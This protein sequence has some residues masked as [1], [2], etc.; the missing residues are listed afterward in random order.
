MKKCQKKPPKSTKKCKKKCKKD[1]KKEKTGQHFRQLQVSV[2]PLCQKT[3]CK[4][5]FYTPAPLP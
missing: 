1:G 2:M 4:L 3:C 5:G